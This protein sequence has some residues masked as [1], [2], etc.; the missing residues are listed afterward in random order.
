MANFSH[1]TDKNEARMVDISEKSD[2]KRTAIVEAF[3]TVNNDCAIQ[4]TTDM[5]RE[6]AS[7]ARVAGVFAAKKTSETI[8]MC[9]PIAISGCDIATTFDRE[10]RVFRITCEAKTTSST[11]VEMEALCG[12]SAAALT[13]Y[14]MIKAVDPAA[15]IGPMQL[16]KKTG[17]KTGV[18]ERP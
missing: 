4:L 16:I 12:V 15:T 9:H 3:V 17:G 6:I 11:G 18:W 2:T 5:L 1:L 10:T 13:I 7:T 8:P 14:D